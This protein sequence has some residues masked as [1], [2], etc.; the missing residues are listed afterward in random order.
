MHSSSFHQQ[1][2]ECLFPKCKESITSGGASTQRGTLYLV[3]QA[4]A[5]FP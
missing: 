5:C 4:L 2:G 3:G 1:Q